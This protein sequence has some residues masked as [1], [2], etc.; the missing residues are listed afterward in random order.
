VLLLSLYLIAADV[1][2]HGPDY[3]RYD[4]QPMPTPE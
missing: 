4:P 2:V 3:Q 1:L